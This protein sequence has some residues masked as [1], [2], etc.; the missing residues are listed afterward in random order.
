MGRILPANRRTAPEMRRALTPLPNGVYTISRSDEQLLTMHEGE[1]VVLPPNGDPGTQEWA[2]EERGDGNVQL[3]NLAS[4]Q[5][6]DFIGSQEENKTLS[7]ATRPRPWSLQQT[8]QPFTFCLVPGGYRIPSPLTVDL[9]PMQVFPPRA[10]LRLRDGD[11]GQA[12]KFNR[13]D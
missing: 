4:E 8:P 12:W 5:Y 11:I 1:A 2:L 13:Q 6:L 9:S 7:G 10:A 3:K